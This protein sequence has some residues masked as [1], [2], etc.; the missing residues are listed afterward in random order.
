MLPDT[1][2]KELV[3]RPAKKIV[4]QSELQFGQDIY[5]SYFLK[6]LST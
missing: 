1:E 6:A 5:Y 4:G 3:K 2:Y